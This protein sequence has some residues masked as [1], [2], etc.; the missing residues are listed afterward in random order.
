[1]MMASTC[2][3]AGNAAGVSDQDPRHSIPSN[4]VAVEAPVRPGSDHARTVKYLLGEVLVA[5]RR[6]TAG[7]TL[8]SETLYKDGERHGL[9]RTW[10]PNGQIKLESPFYQGLMHGTFRQWNEKGQLLGSY[11]MDLG[12]GMKS[13][14]YE[15]GQLRSECPCVDGTAAE[16]CREWYPNGRADKTGSYKNGSEDGVWRTYYPEGQLRQL[17]RFKEGK[18]HGISWIWDSKG[19][20]TEGTP[21]FYLD[22]VRVTEKEYREA[23]VVDRTLPTFTGKPEE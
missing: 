19:A 3:M 4:A 7:G 16:T 6:Y 5:E 22:G 11:E 13:T 1:M 21:L 23:S 2:L 20:L 14:W 10:H 9:E 8:H 15:N 18:A 12:T 17:I